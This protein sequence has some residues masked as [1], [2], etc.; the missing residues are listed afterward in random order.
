[1]KKILL[2]VIPLVLVLVACGNASHPSA[3]VVIKY[4][5][6]KVDSD[7]ETIKT[8]LCSAKES[9][10]PKEAASFASVEAKLDNVQ[11]TFDEATSTVSCTG[12]I[13]ATYNGESRN[14]SLPKFSMVQ[15]DGEWRVCGE[16]E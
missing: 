13:V 6:A 12:N 15:E 16:A 10:A 3:E 11:C 7:V 2:I 8:T 4:L 1:M 9:E 5:Q 14:L